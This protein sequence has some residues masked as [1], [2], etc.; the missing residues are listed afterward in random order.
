[1]CLPCSPVTSAVM[2]PFWCCD[3][4][5]VSYSFLSANTVSWTERV[6]QKIGAEDVNL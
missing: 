4:R 2:L 1:M 5:A 6:L 3:K